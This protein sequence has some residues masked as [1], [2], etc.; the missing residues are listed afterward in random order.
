MVY[1]FTAYGHPN[2]SATH[3]TT[4]EFTKDE[5]VSLNGSCIVGIK[6]DFDLKELKD[7][8]KKSKNEEIEIIIGIKIKKIQEKITA[9][10]N[11]EF[12]SDEELIV[13]KSDFTSERTFGIKSD[14]AAFDLNRGIVP[15]LK[16][17]NNKLIISI[18]FLVII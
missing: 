14:K 2:I 12:N 7:F 8:I 18:N 15:Y 16:E 5:H 17:K 9:K 3:K 1:K 4:L 13:R 10:L 11:P 6:S